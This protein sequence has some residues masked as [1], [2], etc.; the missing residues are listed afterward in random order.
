MRLSQASLTVSDADIA[1]GLVLVA[2]RQGLLFGLAK[3]EPDGEL[4]M[5]FVD[6]LAMNRGVGRL[7][8]EAAVALAR[9]MGARRMAIL[10]DPNAAPFY[11]RMGARFVSQAPS[12][13]IP[14]RT[15]PLYEYDLTR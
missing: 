12:D 1:S 3:V 10:A 15:L 6:P 2:E 8:F 11:E 13:A 4:D 9:R 14:G 7:L 5:M